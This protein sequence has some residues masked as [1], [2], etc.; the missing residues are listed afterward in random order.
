VKVVRM[1]AVG[2]PEVLEL[3]EA[4]EPEPATGRCGSPTRCYASPSGAQEGGAIAK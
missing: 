4:V 2:G 1:T 3:V